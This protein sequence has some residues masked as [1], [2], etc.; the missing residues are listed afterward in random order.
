M[1]TGRYSGLADKIIGPVMSFMLQR[2]LKKF[3][4]LVESTP[5]VEAN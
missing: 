5:L 2:M 1:S 4:R 3:G